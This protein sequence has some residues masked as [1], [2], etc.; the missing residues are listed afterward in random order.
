MQG[1]TARPYAAGRAIDLPCTTH[2]HTAP[3]DV[4][5]ASAASQSTAATEFTVSASTIEVAYLVARVQMVLQILL[6]LRAASVDEFTLDH[7]A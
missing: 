6:I 1:T 3:S 4:R 5:I 7:G 2:S